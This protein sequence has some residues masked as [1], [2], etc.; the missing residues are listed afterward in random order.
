MS[1]AEQSGW[2]HKLISILQWQ[3]GQLR[4]DLMLARKLEHSKE[5]LS[6]VRDTRAIPG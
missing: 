4:V 5:I 2:G 3:L 6:T 1:L